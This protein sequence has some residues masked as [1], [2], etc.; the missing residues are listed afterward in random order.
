MSIGIR[1]LYD[2]CFIIGT[3]YIAK[4]YVPNSK[5]FI[6]IGYNIMAKVN[7]LVNY[8]V[9][10]QFYY[11]IIMYIPIYLYVLIYKL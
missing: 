5:F 3:R 10:S 7:Y 2:C 1:L 9:N 8:P 11:L 6:P 4:H